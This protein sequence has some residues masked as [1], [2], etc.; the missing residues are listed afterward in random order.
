MSLNI[1]PEELQKYLEMGA[2][3]DEILEMLRQKD[4][5]EGIMDDSYSGDPTVNAGA[6]VV[7]NFAD[8]IK[9]MFARGRAEKKIKGLEGDIANKRAGNQQSLRSF[10][11]GMYDDTGDAPPEI[12]DQP[13][14]QGPGSDIRD[15]GV[16]HAPQ[17]PP[18]EGGG[19]VGPPAPAATPPPAPAPAAP[20]PPPAPPPQAPPDM[21]MGGLKDEVPTMA[22]FPPQPKDPNMNGPQDKEGFLQILLQKLRGG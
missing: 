15:L 13:L 7:P 16:P 14:P 20:A 9:G 5:Q 21:S 6:Y 22:S 10:L 12:K 3:E 8:P 11:Q 4:R 1:P 17:V 19:P 18:P 2:N